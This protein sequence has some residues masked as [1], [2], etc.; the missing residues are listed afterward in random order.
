MLQR[1]RNRVGDASLRAS[2]ALM[3]VL[4]LVM[5]SCLGGFEP[6]LFMESLRKAPVLFITIYSAKRRKCTKG[7]GLIEKLRNISLGCKS[8]DPQCPNGFNHLKNRPTRACHGAVRQDNTSKY[9]QS[10]SLEKIK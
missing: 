7:K 8:Q 10:I 4:E 9:S 5:S 3:Y 2:A 1:V 6:S